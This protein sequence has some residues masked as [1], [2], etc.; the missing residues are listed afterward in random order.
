MARR[1]VT[2]NTYPNLQSHIITDSSAWPNLLKTISPTPNI[3][4]SALG[5]T[6]AQ[7]GSFEA[8]HTIDYD[9]NLSLARAAKEAGVRV[10][11][12]IS[13]ARVST[14]SSFPFMRMKAELEEQVKMLGFPH[15]V[16]VRPGLLMGQRQETR[17]AEGVLRAIAKAMGAVSKP[18][19]MDW[20]AVDADVVSRA[21]M[22]AGFTCAEGKRE[23]GVWIIEQSEIIRLGR[24]E[25]KV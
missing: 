9:L 2:P 21:A 17:A 20:W 11:V 22:S 24:T 5:T 19:L 14:N 13:G 16:I 8:Q 6:R 7:A 1:Q 10:Y 15:T 4:F 3:F 23:E 12:L 18:L 25:W